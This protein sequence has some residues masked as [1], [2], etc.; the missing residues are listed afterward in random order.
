[1]GNIK[2][3]RAMKLYHGTTERYLNSI[4]K[5]GISPR[6]RRKSNWNVKSNPRAV[7]LTNVYALHFANAARASGEAALILEIDTDDLNSTLLAPDEDYLEQVSH[8]DAN[9][10]FLR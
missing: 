2:E 7:Y 9:F 1:M 10:E 3:V 8:Y 6:R 5:I 4:L